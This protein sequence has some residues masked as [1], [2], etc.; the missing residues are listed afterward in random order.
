MDKKAIMLVDDE[1]IILMS[2]VQEL[3]TA[4]GPSYRYETA[5]SMQEARDLMAELAL[6]GVSLVACV[7]DWLMPG[8]R[9]DELLLEV[10][11][12]YPEAVLIIVTGYADDSE[13]EQACCDLGITARIHKPWGRMQIARVLESALPKD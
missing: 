12:V 1:A 6:D 11:R 8:G 3:R 2:M 13:V 10:R 5:R 7:S 4:L 9:G